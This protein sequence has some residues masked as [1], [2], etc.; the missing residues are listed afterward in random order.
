M[1]LNQFFQ[2]IVLI[3]VTFFFAYVINIYLVFT[4]QPQPLGQYTGIIVTAIA[5]IIA[6]LFIVLSRSGDK[7]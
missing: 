2:K 6:F 4:N 7:K 5:F 1:V 3:A